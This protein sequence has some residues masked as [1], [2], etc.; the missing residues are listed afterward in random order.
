MN[1]EQAARR[2]R[3]QRVAQARRD[4]ELETFPTTA[5][6]QSLNA[7]PM[8][9][10][11]GAQQS[12]TSRIPGL[13]T[14]PPAPAGLTSWGTWAPAP[15]EH[16]GGGY[17]LAAILLQSDDEG[18]FDGSFHTRWALAIWLIRP[19]GTISNPWVS[20]GNTVRPATQAPAGFEDFPAAY[21]PPYG[22]PT[23]LSYPKL[24]R[25]QE[26]ALLTFQAFV[27]DR[28]YLSDTASFW[29]QY[30]DQNLDVPF[31]ASVYY[32]VG[33]DGTDPVVGPPLELYAGLDDDFPTDGDW[34]IGGGTAFD[35]GIIEGFEVV[36]PSADPN[37]VVYGLAYESRRHRAWLLDKNPSDHSLSLTAR[38]TFTTGQASGNPGGLTRIGTNRWVCLSSPAS[39]MQAALFDAKTGTVIDSLDFDIVDGFAVGP[40]PAVE[41]YFVLA[42]FGYYAAN[43]LHWDGSTVH[44]AYTAVLDTL[45]DLAHRY[46]LLTVD[47]DTLT[48]GTVSEW[49]V[50][51]RLGGPLESLYSSRWVETCEG[52]LRLALTW[53]RREQALFERGQLKAGPE[54][55]ISP[56]DD[57]GSGEFSDQRIVP[58][59]H[60]AGYMWAANVGLSATPPPALT[61]PK[62]IRYP[63]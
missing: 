34:N 50:Q 44:A 32:W 14:E 59:S 19:D 25:W 26:G 60:P 28:Q 20:P 53:D 12:V 4:V 58:S 52:C 6:S 43:H 38:T 63:A 23:D 16:V 18:W 45:T 35:D 10:A 55:L 8:F 57:D 48:A 31:S 15:I 30:V 54:P 1:P 41:C 13:V 9:G 2:W 46:V 29:P 21:A 49:A 40:S 61:R 17:H 42:N 56:E 47:G 37:I 51:D 11:G 5:G 33:H 36:G 3:Q 39:K 62:L 22:E 7:H 24:A 27:E